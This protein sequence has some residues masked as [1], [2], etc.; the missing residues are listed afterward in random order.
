MS[1][2]FG[3][4]PYFGLGFELMVICIIWGLPALAFI[5]LSLMIFKFGTIPVKISLSAFIFLVAVIIIY[6]RFSN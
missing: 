6:K 2:F 4:T 5:Y 3:N 1:Q